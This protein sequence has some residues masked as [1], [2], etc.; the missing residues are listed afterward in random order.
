MVKKFVVVLLKALGMERTLLAPDGGFRCG[1]G[2]GRL[3]RVLASYFLNRPL[4]CLMLAAPARPVLVYVSTASIAHYLPHRAPAKGGLPAGH[5]FILDGDWD[6]AKRPRGV[7]STVQELIVEKKPVQ[8]TR[9]FRRRVKAILRGE[10]ERTQGCRSEADVVNYLEGMK[11]L[12]A[13]ISREGYKTQQ[14]LGLNG[15]DE[16]KVYVGRDGTLMLSGGGNH[17]HGMALYLGI[18]TVPVVI[19]GVHRDWLT[20]ISSG[21]KNPE[22]AVMNC[23]ARSGWIGQKCSFDYIFEPANLPG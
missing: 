19:R 3:R 7:Y 21:R 4:E 17:R 18:E 10:F 16:I 22:A 23:I 5:G 14:E 6:R 20:K 11:E 12:C 9:E 13:K 15:D 1:E 2:F 8:E